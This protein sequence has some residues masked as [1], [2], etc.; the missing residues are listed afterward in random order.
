VMATLG[1]TPCFPEIEEIR[2]QQ[3]ALQLPHLLKVRD[4]IAGDG[5]I[6]SINP[7]GHIRRLDGHMADCYQP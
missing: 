6:G 4:R 3:L 1:R 2:R 7:R 5:C